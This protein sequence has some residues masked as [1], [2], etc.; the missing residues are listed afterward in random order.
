[1]IDE[2]LKNEAIEILHNCTSMIDIAIKKAIEKMCENTYKNRDDFLQKL[3]DK[4][5]V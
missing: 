2:N 4:Y 3:S 1:M 5:L